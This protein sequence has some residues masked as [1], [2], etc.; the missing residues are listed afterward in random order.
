M[1]EIPSTCESGH[2]PVKLK[3]CVLECEIDVK[4]QG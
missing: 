1:N 4:S 3:I 2:I